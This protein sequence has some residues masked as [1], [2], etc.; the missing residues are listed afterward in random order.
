MRSVVVVLPASM[1]AM[2][3]MLR[4]F[5]RENLRGMAQGPGVGGEAAVWAKKMGPS[6]PR[7]LLVIS[8]PVRVVIC[9][10]SPSLGSDSAGACSSLCAGRDANPTIAEHFSALGRLRSPFGGPRSGLAGLAR[11]G[12]AEHPCEP[13]EHPRGRLQVLRRAPRGAPFSTPLPGLG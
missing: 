4:V 7:A 2:I 6:G 5:S 12:L 1:W 13:L 10:R 9:S 8:G 3:P 11:G